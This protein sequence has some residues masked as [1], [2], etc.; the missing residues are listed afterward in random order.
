ML[1]NERET[2]LFAELSGLSSTG[3]SFT[4]P[5]GATSSSRQTL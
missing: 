1:L 5:K 2:E 4:T 3:S